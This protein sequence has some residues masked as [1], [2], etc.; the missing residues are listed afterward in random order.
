MGTICWDCCRSD[1]AREGSAHGGALRLRI[2]LTGRN[3]QVGSA[4]ARALSLVGDVVALGRRELDLTNSAA[5]AAK[6][7]EIRPELVINAAA[8]TGVDRAE[9]EREAA[10][11]VNASAV[12]ALARAARDNGA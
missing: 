7:D 12:A 9:L 5:I 6:V 10:F 4:L 8:Y 1:D 3:G 11:A 2:L